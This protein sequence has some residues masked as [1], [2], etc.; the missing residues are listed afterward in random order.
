MGGI[1]PISGQAHHFRRSSGERVLYGIE[2]CTKEPRRL[3]TVLDTRLVDQNWI[4][5]DQYFT[6]DTAIFPLCAMFEWL[7]ISLDEFP[8]VKRW[9]QAVGARPAVQ[10]GMV[11]M[12][13]RGTSNT[14]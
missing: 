3:W 5:A 10:R 11:P 6:A 1:A 14:F 8:N 4:A 2:R 9:Y 7:G 12:Q 13:P